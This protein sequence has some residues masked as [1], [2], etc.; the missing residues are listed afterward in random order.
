MPA[1]YSP[2]FLVRT[3]TDVF[4]VETKAQSALSDEN[5]KRKQRAALSWCEQLN[6]LPGHQ[7]AD[8]SWHYVLLGESI[9]R[10]WHSKNVRATELLEYARLRRSDGPAQGTLL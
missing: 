8:L 9:V 7:R 3:D 4:V 10:E 6:Q 2:Y 1:Q 5:V